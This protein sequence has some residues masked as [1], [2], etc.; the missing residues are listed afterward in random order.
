MNKNKKQQDIAQRQYS[1]EHL[2]FGQISQK[3]RN[4]Q[5]LRFRILELRNQVTKPSYAKWRHTSSY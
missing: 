3:N 2:S 5:I 1:I 4:P